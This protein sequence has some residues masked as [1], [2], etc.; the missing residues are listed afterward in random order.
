MSVS[1]LKSIIIREGMETSGIF[2]LT[3]K[4][5]APKQIIWN[6]LT[7][8]A[9]LKENINTKAVSEMNLCFQRYKQNE[10]NETPIVTK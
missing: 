5:Y 1:L 10:N 8:V 3:E 4:R 9:I 2:L 6:K 7:G